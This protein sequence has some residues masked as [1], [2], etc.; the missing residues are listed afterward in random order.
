MT[1]DV[2]LREIAER[3]AARYT[4]QLLTAQGW[5]REELVDAIHGRLRTK[6]REMRDT[7]TLIRDDQ[8]VIRVARP[9][10]R[11]ACPTPTKRR[12][13]SRAA[14]RRFQRR[15]ELPGAAKTQL[16]PYECPAGGHWHLTHQ[17]P[18]QQA[19]IAARI[20]KTTA[21]PAST[22]RDPVEPGEQEDVS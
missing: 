21:P 19:E 20:A 5:T 15:H 2:E 10:E 7:G 12:H 16:W 13:R 14:A 22:V 4:D 11:D 3:A 18:E 1:V 6:Y 9:L 8:G 17:T